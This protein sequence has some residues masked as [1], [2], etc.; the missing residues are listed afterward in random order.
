MRTFYEQLVRGLYGLVALPMPLLSVLFLGSWFDY[1]PSSTGADFLSMWFWGALVVATLL[2]PSLRAWR[3]M[4]RGDGLMPL[5]SVRSRPLPAAFTA[6]TILVA[7]GIA[8]FI[9]TAPR[10]F[11]PTVLGVSELLSQLWKTVIAL[12]SL[13]LLLGE[14]AVVGRDS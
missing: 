10:E 5:D 9:A 2:F 6:T 7:I 4:W 11:F 1:A 14:W 3:R 12:C 13:A 8:V